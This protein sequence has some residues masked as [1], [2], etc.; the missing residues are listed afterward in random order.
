VPDAE[1]AAPARDDTDQPD[2][3]DGERS[4]PAMRV[5]SRQEPR[6]PAPPSGRDPFG[7]GPIA[8]DLG[9]ILGEDLE[10]TP[11]VDPD[12]GAVEVD[13]SDALAG[14]KGAPP[15][16]PASKAAPPST[17]DGVFA[18]FREEVA[19]HTQADAED[20]HFK[21]GVT[22][23]E[24][25]MVPEAMKELE[26]AVRSPRLR[27]EAASRLARLALKRGRPLDAVEWFERAAEAPA[28]T[29]DAGRTLLYDLGD[30]LEAAGETARALAVFLELQADAIDFR[31]VAR[32]VERLARAQAGG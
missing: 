22:Y 30:T 3:R 10:G 15:A 12:R 8:I 4:A 11:P 21:V 7:L 6:R 29:A 14:L 24:M 32:R 1:A 17:L 18:D 31:D 2:T 28:P 25:G 13:L 26:V 27:F 20:Q 23:E 9:D 19:R 16:P 5:A